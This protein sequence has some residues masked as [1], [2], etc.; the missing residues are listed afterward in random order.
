MQAGKLSKGLVFYICSDIVLAGLGWFLFFFYRKLY[1]QRVAFSEEF[2]KDANLQ[3][4]L[5]IMPGIWLTLHLLLDSYRSLYRMSRMRELIRTFASTA[6]GSVFIF[7]AF[8]LDDLKYYP[9]SYQNYYQSFLGLFGIHFGLTSFMRLL[10]LSVSSQQIKSGKV[11]FR[12]LIVGS[13]QNAVKLYQEIANQKKATGYDFIGYITINA[14]HFNG[15]SAHLEHLGEIDDLGKL[16]DQYQIQE[17]ILALEQSEHQRTQAILN[18]LERYQHH[19]LI[20]VIPDMY[21]ILL[22]NVKMNHVYGAILI[23]ISPHFIQP[24]LRVAKRTTDVIVSSLVILVLFPLYLFVA[25]R[26][27]LSSRGNIFYKQERVGLY[28]RPFVIY[29]FRSMYTGAEEQGPQLSSDTDSRITPWGKIM[30]RYRLDELPQFWNVLKGNM[31]LVGPR[32]ERQFYIEQIAK[33]APYVHQLHKVRPGITSWGQ[34]KYGYASNV[35]E[36]LQRLKYDILYIENLSYS[37]DIKILFY[38]VLVILQG[39]GK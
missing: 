34:V 17:V 14:E 20:K 9:N 23:E 15:L 4:G 10:I 11:A 2:F 8:L 24:W 22:G 16:I 36:M 13:N 18:I 25:L 19:L 12:T 29:K 33:Q 31:S 30:R 1:V 26:V 32:P 21:D 6:L 28:G 37:L 39:R 5:L 27:R 7:F 38:T 35:E 3:Y